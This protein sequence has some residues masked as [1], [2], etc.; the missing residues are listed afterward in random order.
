MICVGRHTE[1]VNMS[2][3]K[4][5]LG[6]LIE[7][8]GKLEESAR[9][10]QNQ[11]FADLIKGARGRLMQASEHPDIDLVEAKMHGDEDRPAEDYKDRP[12]EDHKDRP[13][14]FPGA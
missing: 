1:E 6:E 14:A 9:K 12:A 5:G 2:N 13:A 3:L 4:N 10:L 8:L 11:N 7:H